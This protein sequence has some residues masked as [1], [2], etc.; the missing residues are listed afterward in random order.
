MVM[1]SSCRAPTCCLSITH[2]V[3]LA[4]GG[5]IWIF[6]IQKGRKSI[7]C[8]QVIDIVLTRDITEGVQFP[9]LQ[10]PTQ[11]GCSN[12]DVLSAIHQEFKNTKSGSLYCPQWFV[13]EINSWGQKRC[14]HPQILKNLIFDLMHRKTYSRTLHL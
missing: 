8:F 5:V 10:L 3:L 12:D 1:Y 2:A 6:Y 4:S 13:H 7:S 14:N 11:K 9:P